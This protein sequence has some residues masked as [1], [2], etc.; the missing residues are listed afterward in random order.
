MTPS[1]S[2]VPLAG[3]SF[4]LVNNDGTDPVSGSFEGLPEGSLVSINGAALY[5]TYIGGDGNDVEIR[6]PLVVDSLADSGAGSLRQLI[7]DAAP[8]DTIIVDPSLSGDTITLTSGE[9]LID[10]SLSLKAFDLPQGITISGNQSSR[11]FNIAGGNSVTM[12]GITVSNGFTPS[13]QDGGGI[14]NLGTLTLLNSTFSYNFSGRYGGAI[15]NRG[16]LE[17]IHCTVANNSAESDAGGVDNWQAISLT[18]SN[19]TVSANTS[20]GTGGGIWSS[21]PLTFSNTLVAVSYTHLTLPT[22]REV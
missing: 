4:V 13:G 2:F 15:E 9:L 6:P 19:S 16:I 11:V 10:E 7:A 1:G 20:G 12:A 5:I 22:N 14:Y 3:Q 17:M 18:M 21:K 8:G